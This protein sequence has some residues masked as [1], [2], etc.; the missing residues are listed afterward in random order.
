MD[1]RVAILDDNI[2][3]VPPFRAEHGL[4]VWVEVDGRSFLWDCG[5]SD[6]AVYNARVL[7][8]DLRLIEGIGISHG[9]LDHAGG[10][11]AVLGASGRKKL[12][13]HP[14]AWLPRYLVGGNTR[15]FVGIPHRLDAT[16]SMCEAVIFSRESVEVM[17]GVRLTGEVPRVTDFEG[18]EPAL[19]IERDGELVP[20]PFIDDQA[21]VVDTPDGAVVLTG[22]A[23]SG[24]VN[25]LKHI[26]AT[27]SS[28]K[29]RAVVGGT[30]LGMG[31]PISKVEATM[32]YL[33]EIAP[34]KM[35]FNH[36]T[37]SVVMSRMLDRFGGRFVPGNTGLATEV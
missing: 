33:E 16:E 31:A 13:A 17:P 7:G 2:A 27:S 28:G 36:C 5:L 3:G 8:I 23:H 37:G 12:Y 21:L 25:I 34:G 15:I 30:H 4:S 20:D 19:F 26:L 24:T 29:I 10:L 35:I 14:D 6:L 18:P 22:C 32:D 11:L 1:V 9:H